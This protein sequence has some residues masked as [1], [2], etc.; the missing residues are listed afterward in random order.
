MGTGLAE[1]LSHGVHP[2]YRRS[3]EFFART[4]VPVAETL[5]RSAFASLHQAGAERVHVFTRMPGE[6]RGAIGF[7]ERLGFRTEGSVRRFG[8]ECS[9]GVRELTATDRHPARP[10][11]AP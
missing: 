5:V 4:G 8:I 11:G 7:F 2:E 1:L 9:H 3:S 10:P 6:D